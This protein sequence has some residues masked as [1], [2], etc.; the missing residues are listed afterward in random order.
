MR[1]LIYC[2]EC[3][4]KLEIVN[5]DGRERMKCRFCNKIAYENPVPATAAVVFNK[6]GELLLVKRNVEPKNGEWCLPGGFTEIGE[7]PEECCIR[8]L[9]EETGLEG[10]IEGIIAS[11]PGVNPF[12]RS[13]IVTGYSIKDYSGV[14]KA[15]DDSDESKFFKLGEK[16]PVAFKSHREILDSYSRSERYDIDKSILKNM[17]AYVITSGD[18]IGIAEEACKGGARII[19][20]RDKKA[21]QSEKLMNAKLICKV[22]RKTGTLFI[23]NDSVDI[24]LL[25]GAD[26]V[27]LGQDDLSVSEAR[28]IVPRNF[29]IGK[30]TH[31]LEQAQAAEKDGADYIG[32]GPVFKTP[33]KEDYVPI[34][35]ELAREVVQRVKIPVVAIGGL[36]IDNLELLTGTGLENF[37]MVRE[38]QQNTEENVKKINKLIFY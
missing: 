15:G 22:T 26:G 16:P 36:N 32:I 10:T 6:D 24:A 3:G 13:V 30:S 34:G 18:H 28:K 8:E 11:V 5:A 20:Y 7:T 37:A 19:Q 21:T 27:H 29:I 33:T 1:E 25:S 17:G 35:V 23:V 14:L 2:Q 38:F 12:Y 31:S 4:K 9:R